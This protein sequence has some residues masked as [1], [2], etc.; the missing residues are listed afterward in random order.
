MQSAT[1]K[2]TIM[3]VDDDPTLAKIVAEF[4]KVK[5]FSATTTYTDPALALSA[6]I[7]GEQPCLVISDFTMP[8]M[9][10]AELLKAIRALDRSIDGVI[11][12]GDPAGARS[13]DCTVPIID[14]GRCFFETIVNHVQTCFADRPCN[15]N[16]TS[17][18]VAIF[19]GPENAVLANSSTTAATSSL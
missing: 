7:N 15:V 17:S 6:V 19:S 12:T 1:E 18:T 9:N 11:M 3:I 4:L 13:A 5:G 10:G 8:E 14:K 16:L 2:F